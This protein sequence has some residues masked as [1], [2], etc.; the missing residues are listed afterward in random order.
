MAAFLEQYKVN[1]DFTTTYTFQGHFKY[2]INLFVFEFIIQL[3]TC[4]I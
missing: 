4:N 2:Y 3:T 1:Q